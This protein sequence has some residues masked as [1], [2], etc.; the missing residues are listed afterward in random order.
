MPSSSGWRMT[1]SVSRRNSGSSSRNSTPRWAS[2]ISPGRGV[3]PPPVRPGAE[4][5]WCG[6]RKG[7]RRTSGD[8]GVSRP[9]TEWI[10]VTSSAS[11]RV[12]SGRMDGKRRASMLLPEPGGPTSSTLCAPAAATSS[13]RLTCSCPMTSL[14][15]GRRSSVSSGCQAGSGSMENSPRRWAASCRTSFTGMTVRPPASVASRAFSAGTYSV[16]I[17]AFRAAMAMGSTPLTGRSLPSRL[18]SPRKADGSRG[19]RTSSC[20]ARMPSR[21]GRS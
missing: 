11:S 15:S 12:I 10:C 14:K 17:P 9:M 1:S 21:I 19:R 18:S 5:V 4:I 6:L 3:E 13:A 16:R 2:E 8:S 20:A 7:R